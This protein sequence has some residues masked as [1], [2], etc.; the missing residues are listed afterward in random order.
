LGIDE[1]DKEENHADASSTRTGHTEGAAVRPSGRNAGL[2]ATTLA[3]PS[4]AGVPVTDLL[5]GGEM[6]I[7]RMSKSE[8]LQVQ[9]KHVADRIPVFVKTDI[10]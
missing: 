1:D 10:F 6:P 2:V 7:G 3:P 8:S 4:I 5:L 9:Q